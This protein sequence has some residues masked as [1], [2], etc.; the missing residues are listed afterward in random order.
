M[1]RRSKLVSSD[2]MALEWEKSNLFDFK[3]AEVPLLLVSRYLVE[4]SGR[5]CLGSYLARELHRCVGRYKV[6]AGDSSQT[7]R[8]TPPLSA[9]T[10]RSQLPPRTFSAFLEIGS[11]R[12]AGVGYCPIKLSTQ[13]NFVSRQLAESI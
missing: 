4:L 1:T 13:R 11:K 2:T 7:G 10:P 6:A 8:A 9:L 3:V 5:S 12:L